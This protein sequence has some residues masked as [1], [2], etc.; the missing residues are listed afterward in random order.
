MNGLMIIIMLLHPLVI[1]NK[2][3]EKY[4]QCLLVFPLMKNK[5]LGEQVA[6]LKTNEVFLLNQ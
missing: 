1:L 5:F 4:F 2:S 3:D 6:L